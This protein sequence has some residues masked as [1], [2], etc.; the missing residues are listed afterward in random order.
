VRDTESGAVLLDLSRHGDV[1]EY[2]FLINS[3]SEHLEGTLYGDKDT[4]ALAFAAAGKPDAFRQVAVPPGAML[5]WRQGMLQHRESGETSAGW[6]LSGM[7]QFDPAGRPVFA[8]RT[9][10][11]IR[12][13]RPANGGPDGGA[14]AP[15]GAGA[16]SSEPWP[17]EAL[18]GPLPYGWVRYFLDQKALGPTVGVPF[19]YVVPHSA[20]SL[21]ALG[22]RNASSPPP[23]ASNA[24]TAPAAAAAAGGQPPASACRHDAWRRYW[25]IRSLALPLGGVPSLEAAC[26]PAERARAAP[27]YDARLAHAPEARFLAARGEALNAPLAADALYA[28]AEELRAAYGAPVPALHMGRLEEAWDSE[29]AAFARACDAA[30]R[31]LRVNVHRFPTVARGPI[32]KPSPPPIEYKE[33][34]DYKD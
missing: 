22:P 8:H 20:L 13:P 1:A 3:F 34:K 19:D 15:P 14:G 33:Y 23:A 16:E 17:L 2:L 12:A 6:Q 28:G 24:S 27:E 10:N 5:S 29:L 30:W 26:S 31:W 4:F 11:K 7:I 21:V 9:I 18:T 25:R 32:A